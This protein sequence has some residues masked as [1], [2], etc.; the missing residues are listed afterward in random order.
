MKVV[1]ISLIIVQAI[2][3]ISCRK[4]NSPLFDGVNCAGNCY[5]LTGNIL[6]SASA[7]SLSNAEVKFFYKVQAGTFSNKTY[8]I[9]RAF[10]DQNGNYNFKFDGSGYKNPNGYFF[11]EAYKGNLF[12]DPVYD[13]RVSV[14]YLDSTLFNI[15]IVQNFSL[16]R[17]AI[18]KIHVI[19][20]T[21]INFK[22]LTIS[23]DYGRIDKGIVLNGGQPIN[24]VLVYKTAGDI[25]TFIKWDAK[26]NGVNIERKDTIIVPTGGVKE[27]EIRL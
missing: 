2:S 11:T 23:Y 27:I 19:A 18:L 8:Y 21:I 6:D 4:N 24:T 14:F 20:S 17:P 15:P 5:V 3:L 10:T 22:S 16:F 1:L 7:L 26:G 9:G 12:N 13:N 25:R